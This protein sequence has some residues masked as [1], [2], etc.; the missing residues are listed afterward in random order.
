MNLPDLRETDVVVT[1]DNG[2]KKY[3]YLMTSDEFDSI[4]EMELQ[5]IEGEIEVNTISMIEYISAERLTK[6]HSNVE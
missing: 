4:D 2:F 5:N 1:I 6:E 3:T